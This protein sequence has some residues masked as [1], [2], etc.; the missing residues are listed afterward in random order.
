MVDLALNFVGVNAADFGRAFAFYTATLGVDP[1]APTPPEDAES[2]AMLVAGWDD[3]PVADAHD[4]RCELFERASD[5]PDERWWG[6]NQN[7]RPAIAVTDLEGTVATLQDRG[8]P[9]TGDIEDT[10]WGRL[11]EFTAPEGVRWSLATTASGPA[12]RGVQTPHIGW[13]ELKAAD[14]AAQVDFY[15]GILGLSVG[16]RSASR[17]RLEQGAGE[18]LLFLESGG[19]RV[20]HGADADAA[21]DGHPV[22]TSVETSDVTE[23]AGWFADNG[24]TILQEVTTHDWGGTDFAIADPDGNPLQVVEYDHE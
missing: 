9:F 21:F 4:L 15:T 17:V 12:G 3:S 20:P 16:E 23:A 14:L 24:V 8:V 22:W 11:V 13:L 6:R 18:P 19:E 7:V 1:A 5:P 2:W 10:D